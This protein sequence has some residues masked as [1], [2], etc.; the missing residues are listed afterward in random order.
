[1]DESRTHSEAIIGEGSRASLSNSGAAR[2]IAI[3]IQLTE[4]RHHSY[5]SAKFRV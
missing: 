2:E 4:P 5:P 1:M 3:V